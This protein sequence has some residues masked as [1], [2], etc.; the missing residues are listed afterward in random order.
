MKKCL[1]PESGEDSLSYRSHNTYVE[2]GLCHTL[3]TS[4]L[5]SHLQGFTSGVVLVGS[6]LLISSSG[7]TGQLTIHD[8]WDAVAEDREHTDSW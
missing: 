2:V 7:K 3:F 6:C 5:E 4:Y 8:Y 1:D